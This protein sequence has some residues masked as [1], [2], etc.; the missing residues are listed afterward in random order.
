MHNSV[1]YW[2]EAAY[3]AN[4]PRVLQLAGHDEA[5]W[6]AMRKAVRQLTRRWYNKFDVM[7]D[8]LA[9]WFARS[10]A[11]RSDATLKKAL[12]DGGF[13]VQFSLTPAQRDVLEATIQANVALI[14]SI[15][16][17]Y[18]SQVEELVMASVQQGR[19]LDTL[20]D[21]LQQRFGSTR[22]CAILISRD[23]NNK[24]TAALERVRRLE[25]GIQ[26]AVWIHSHAGKKPRPTH[27][28]MHGQTF[29]VAEGMWDPAE[30]RY[31]QP[32][33]LINCRCVSK[34]IIPGFT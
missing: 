22:K 2:V 5:P 26:K 17:R 3:K 29:D 20:T 27:V 14:K 15:P 23:Q 28:K 31:V 6:A 24:A 25:L 8:R 18:L 21:E 4:P 33:E 7:A 34:S 32:G 10:A 19:K 13:A 9:R 30:N 11:S 1:L 16:Q 12:K